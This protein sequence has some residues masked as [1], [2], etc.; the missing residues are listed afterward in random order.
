DDRLL[1]VG[2]VCRDLTCLVFLTIY[3]QLDYLFDQARFAK[4]KQYHVTVNGMMDQIMVE[5][6]EKGLLLQDGTQLKPAK[7]RILNQ[8]VSESS[9]IVTITEGK[10]HQIKRMFLQCGVKVTDLHRMMIGPLHL[11][12]A[13]Q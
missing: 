5:A 3:G 2:S 6:F 13:T 12:G 7:L 11:D 1:I 8:S 4:E 9:G 10:R